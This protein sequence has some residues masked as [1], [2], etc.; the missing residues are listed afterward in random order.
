MMLDKTLKQL[1]TEHTGKVSDK[2]SSYIHE[3][4]RIFH[5]YRKEPVRLLEIGV[6]N[7]GSLEIWSKYFPNAKKL[8]GCDIDPE[9]ARLIYDDPRIAVVVQ[10]ANSDAAQAS[11][12][13]NSSAFD[14]II[15]DGSHLSADIAKSFARYFPYLEDGGIFVAE[16]LHCSYWRQF[17]GGLYNPYSSITFFK[18]LADIINHEHWG[19]EKARADILKGFL[20]KYDFQI[21]EEVLRHIHSV[22]FINSMCVIRKSKPQ[23]NQVG[24]RIITGKSD[25]IMQ[26]MQASLFK[27]IDQTDNDWTTRDMPPDE[28]LIIRNEELKVLHQTLADTQI[29][30]E[31]SRSWRITKPL[32]VAMHQAKHIKKAF[33]ASVTLLANINELTRVILKVRRKGIGS[34]KQQ[35]ELL[36]TEDH[37]IQKAKD[38]GLSTE[39][40][41]S[42]V[43]LTK[44][45]V[46]SKRWILS[47]SLPSKAL[48]LLRGK[49]AVSCKPEYEKIKVHVDNQQGIIN[50]VNSPHVISG[51]GVDL[52]NCSRAKVRMIIGDTVH[53]TR[54]VL[55]EDVQQEFASICEMPPDTG[56]AG[57]LTLPVGLHRIR[58]EVEVNRGEWISVYRALLFCIPRMR[59]KE[60]RRRNLSYTDWIKTNQSLLKNELPEIKRHINVMIYKP[61]FTVIVQT[62]QDDSGLKN[63]I[64]SLRGQ[65]YQDYDIRLLTGENAGKATHLKSGTKRLQDLSLSDVEGDFIIFIQSGQLLT[66]NALYEFASKLNQ[67]PNIDLIYGDEDSITVSGELHSPFYKPDWSPDYLETFN[68][69]GFTACFRTT[70]ARG[71]FD[72]ADPYDFVL[73][74]TEHATEIVHLPKVVGHQN[75]PLPTEKTYP[76]NNSEFNIKALQARLER[77]GRQG[78][79]SEHSVHKGCYEMQLDLKHF[80]LVSVVIPTAGKTV[81]IQGRSINLIENIVKQIRDQSTY[82]NIEI[83]VVD[84]GDLSSSQLKTLSDAGCRTITYSDSVFNVPKKLNL[85]VT[86]ANGELLLLM[87]DD[88]E[89][90][91]PSWIERMIEHFEKPHVGVVGAKLLYPS[92]ETQHVGV[93]HNSGNPDHV[94]RLY[95]KDEAGYFFSTC[96]VRNYSAV[97]G[98]CMMTRT[99]IYR[100]VGGYSEELAISYNDA[101]YCMKIRQKGMYTLYAPTAILTHMESQSRIASADESEVEWYQNH[102]ADQVFS[103][104]FYNERFLTVASPTFEPYI[105]ERMV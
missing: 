52:A 5:E 63:T 83:I 31:N 18:R 70:I 16:D 82:K 64:R 24:T 25:A 46:H 88:I 34:A 105:N 50:V 77:T 54:H 30:Y 14:L 19:I 55:R 74:F 72:N 86:V 85:G 41:S 17:E 104:P 53:Q 99:S 13:K 92:G 95:P 66:S 22:E 44:L 7:G 84:N 58:I 43:Y 6:Q 20:S 49:T 37:I 79:V 60:M 87:N 9:C 10:D 11:I 78:K 100:E 57:L 76:L 21:E 81:N 15:D 103:D 42:M 89:I 33:K 71:C 51:W 26:G 27:T 93:V 1:C 98:A 65:I 96:G 29:Y 40:I 102:W 36:D 73:Q 47:K 69:I 90:I 45:L 35:L 4:D 75:R 61:K 12:L 59:I 101:D 3:Y 23:H 94:R 97:T 56:F 32:R 28:E 2:W 67:H 68:Y 8:V 48:R 39:F 80:P 38:R 91:N 62:K